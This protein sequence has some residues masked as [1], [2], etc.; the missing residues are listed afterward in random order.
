MTKFKV[1]SA[2]TLVE[3]LVVIAIIALLLAA[4]LP[5]FSS[6][7]NQAKITD[8][9]AKFRAL[10]TGIRTFQG[11]SAIGGALP[12]SS[13]DDPT[14][15]QKIADPRG[16]APGTK[17]RVAGAQLLVHAMLGAD[18]LGTPGFRDV[19]RGSTGRGTWSDDTHKGTTAGTEGIYALDDATGK[20]KFPRYG[21]G[22][23]VDQKL[24]SEA[25]SLQEL[26][27]AG[28]IVGALPTVDS[29]AINERM[30]LDPWDHPILYYRANASLIRMTGSTAAPGIYWQEDNS[31]ITGTVDGAVAPED[32]IDFGQGKEHDTYHAIANARGPSP[33]AQTDALALF[34]TDTQ[35]D[36]T[37][38][39]YIVDPAVK[40]RLTPVNKDS[41]LLISAGPDSRYGTGDDIVNWT[42]KTE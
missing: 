28:K 33:S 17:I 19:S 37:F 26:F 9:S 32:G 4:L 25:K 20:E 12:P 36:R 11:E 29:P 27:N 16:T 24:K 6:V 15:R 22:G 10:D 31:L 40:A 5:A 13:T 14:H 21:G 39:K 8:T 3:M 18:G 35:Y 2:F 7:R 30:F 34:L 41:Y 23:Y 1:R 42:K 38:A